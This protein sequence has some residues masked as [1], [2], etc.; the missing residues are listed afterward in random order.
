VAP[1]PAGD[2]QARPGGHLDGVHTHIHPPP[3]PRASRPAPVTG[4]VPALA[5]VP[6]TVQS[7][8]PLI[9]PM[10]GQEGH[11]MFWAKAQ[12]KVPDGTEYDAR[13]SWRIQKPSLPLW[14]LWL[15]DFPKEKT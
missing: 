14:P 5:A 10:A 2:I 8:I 11:A 9:P 15:G 13:S 6:S 4:L 12:D 3:P 1:L 7:V